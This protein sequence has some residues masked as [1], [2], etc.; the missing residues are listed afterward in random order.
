[1]IYF[2]SCT[3][4]D[5]PVVLFGA[6]LVSGSETVTTGELASLGDICRSG[7][8]VGL[9]GVCGEGRED[10][11]LGWDGVVVEFTGGL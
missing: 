2:G 6:V 3:V 7:L 5:S 11:G 8:G 10:W 4:P 9:A 1:M